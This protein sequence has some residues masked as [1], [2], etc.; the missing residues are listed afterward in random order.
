MTLADASLFRAYDVRGCART[1][2]TP[3][4][5]EAIA[6]AFAKR[7][8]GTG[9]RRVL[10]GRDGRLSSP[11][12]HAA[13]SETFI[14]SGLDV[15]DIGLVPTPLLYF[16]QHHFNCGNA[17]MITGSHNPK[18]DNGF[19]LGLGGRPFF[20]DA[21]RALRD[22]ITERPL[23]RGGGDISHHDIRTDYIRAVVDSV[24][25]ARPLA[26]AIDCGNGVAGTVARDLYTALGCEVTALYDTVDGEFPHHHPDPAVAENLHDLA[27]RV[28]DDALSVGLA[29]DG[30]GDRLGVV[31]N[32]GQRIAADR[33]MM[34]FATEVLATHAGAAVVFDVKCS[35]AL[36]DTVLRAGGK[37]FY[38]KTGHAHLKSS[39]REHA[40][41]LAGEL[42]GHLL[43]ADRWFGFDDALYAGAR[44][45]EHL[46]VDPASAAK[47]FERFP[48]G[49]AT[50]EL[51]LPCPGFDPHTI[52]Q[53]LL[54]SA[55]FAD[56]E[57][58]TL[59]GLRVDFCD[60]WGLLRASNTTANLVLRFEG[61]S[62]TA[63]HRIRDALLTALQ[64]AAPDLTLPEHIR[65]AD[66]P[67]T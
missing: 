50:E 33:L 44:L 34:L 62:R 56:A 11:D 21:L 2:L 43:F 18:H 19:K 41:P 38:C 54:A 35:K 40:A 60:G 47:R 16:A 20:G 67:T 5:A 28:T 51:L 61:D 57:V 45:L 37:P 64:S 42:S 27:T 59:D 53:A 29:F 12:L 39:A 9:D 24:R 7:V 8:R 49:Y 32:R 3:A 48:V 55:A 66:A 17:L 15:L 63:L 13:V 31:D 46:A 25:L 23:R 14:A 52:A 1:L 26:V 36:N 10:L 30:D 58:L 4:V 6:G 65:H 22:D